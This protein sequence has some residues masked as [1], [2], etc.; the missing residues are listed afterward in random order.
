MK[1]SANI[2]LLLLCVGILSNVSVAQD[3]EDLTKKELRAL[4]KEARKMDPEEFY[5]MKQDLSSLKQENANLS[6]QVTSLESKLANKDN[7]AKQV[8]NE[9]RQVKQQLNDARAKAQELVAKNVEVSSQEQDYS[10]GVVFRVQIGAFRNKDLEKYLETSE[11]FQGESEDGLK[12][13]TLG[14]FRDYWEAD[15]FKKYLREMG[16]KDAWIVPYRDGIRVSVKEVLENQAIQP[17][18]EG[19]GTQE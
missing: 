2:I 13:Y 3:A 11:N 19:P 18:G 7:Q 16:V 17:E 12:K 5:K 8:Q 14:N 9:L 6:S 10:E 4:K 1:L 15:T